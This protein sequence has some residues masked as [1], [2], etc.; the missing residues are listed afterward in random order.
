MGKV[1]GFQSNK[2]DLFTLKGSTGL[3][4]PFSAILM[5]PGPVGRNNKELNE[6]ADGKEKS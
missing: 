5:A 2:R 1:I 6:Q 4:L 3:L